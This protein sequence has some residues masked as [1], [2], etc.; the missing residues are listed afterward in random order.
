[1][2]DR[3]AI[4]IFF[5]LAY[6]FTWANWL[7]QAL[8]SRGLTSIQIPGFLAI[9]A[10]YAPALAAIIVTAMLS[11]RQGLRELFR[12]LVRWRVGIQWY[13]VALL[14]PVSITLI[15]LGIH[16]LTGG[17]GPDFTQAAF[18]FGPPE[19]PVWQKIT[20]LFLIFILGF[21]GLGEELGWRGFAL[22]HL[23]EGRSALA[24]SLILGLL[25]AGWHLPYALTEGSFLSELPLPIFF[26]DL[27]AVSTLY[28]WL[29]NHTQGSILL[30]ILFH[31][32]GNV[33][34]NLLPILP[35]VAADLRIF[36]FTVGIHWSVALMLIY[37]A[38]PALNSRRPSAQAARTMN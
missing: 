35:P 34:S 6:L 37:V 17:I 32:A 11:G 25:W 18:P 29:F 9:L 8:T 38:G 4:G 20:L 28:T 16:R 1:M 30:A 5:L 13:G 15:A 3:T 22:P 7:P 21:D 26:L 10:G 14:L 2:R 36:Y 33:S 19:T 31:A 12:R 23:Q 27:L 24:A